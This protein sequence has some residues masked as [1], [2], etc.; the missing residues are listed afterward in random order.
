MVLILGMEGS[1]NKL[2][3]G[4]VRDGEV[5]SNPRVT[6]VTPPGQGFKPTETAR[7][8]QSHVVQ[9]VKRA[10]DEAK[11]TPEEL[12]A[13]AYTK[14]PG[15]GGPLQV[16]AI[17]ARVLAQLWNKPIIGVN[18]CVA[19]I[20]MGRQVTGAKSPIVLYVSGGNTQVIAFSGG[21]YRI[22]GETL[23]IALGNCLD[24]RFARVINLSNDPSPG[25]NIEKAARE[26]VK[27]YEL[28]YAVKGMDVSFAGILSYLKERAPK[29]LSSGEYTQADLCFSLQET[30]FAMVVEITERAM[31]H[32]DTKVCCIY[33]YEPSPLFWFLPYLESLS[34]KLHI[35]A[36]FRISDRCW[37]ADRRFSLS[38]G[39]LVSLCSCDEF[40]E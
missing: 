29:L 7:H 34:N 21:K 2:G 12:D 14:G 8:H 15:M 26:G 32:C 19:H 35:F 28:P 13:I 37:C 10:L 31:A 20:E 27:F 1:A 3:V 36:N 6:Y 39:Q 38:F 11:V 16:V 4:V 24:S 23:D 9:V 18:H 40:S 33:V 17:V 22:F 30:V 5:L 25:F